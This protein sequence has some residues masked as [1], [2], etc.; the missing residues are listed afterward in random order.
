MKGNTMTA[1]TTHKKKTAPKTA[2]LITGLVLIALYIGMAVYYSGHFFPKTTVGGISCG[3]QTASYVEKENITR[4]NEYLL[5]IKDRKGSSFSIAGKDFDYAYDAKGE[6]LAILKKQNAFAWPVG[7]F[8]THDIEMDYSFTYDNDALSSKIEEL[9]LF[10][11]DY[12]ETPK[13]AY[14]DITE[15]DYKV[16]PEVPGNEPISEQVASEITLAIDEQKTDLTL[17]DDCYVNP[18]VYANDSIIAD[19]AAQIDSY[20]AATVH[21]EIDGVDENVDK[22]KILSLLDI[23]EDGTV[24]IND[25]RL[26]SY[27]QHLASTYNTYGDVR[28][29]KT[30]KGDTVKVGGG[31]YGWVISKEK[32]KKQLKKDLKG[33]KAVSREPV[34]EQTAIQS[35]L[36]DIGD[37]YVEID[38]TNQHLWFYKEGKLITDT[39]IVSGNISLKNGSPDGIYKVVY[40]ERDATLVGENYASKVKY[41]MPFAYN[42]GIH[43]AGW[44]DKFGGEI[45]KKNGSHGCINVP[46]K[47]AKKLYQTLDTG[48]P[49]IA[50]YRDPVKLTAENARIS[51]AYSYQEEN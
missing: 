39:D 31:D 3:N 34:Y 40:K 45:Y 36:D 26:T 48:T 43:D 46:P 18:G 9:P 6:E 28:K 14:L 21:Y 30:S 2:L 29:F 42:V 24:S 25:D 15:D 20:T 12:I 50:Y 23:G 8:Q 19:T 33:G 10:A 1:K 16:V 4:A 13:D 47:I 49:V 37:T 7:I 5:T 27:V 51:N 38:Y 11:K 44:R 17:S 32:E 41:F 35:G 22:K